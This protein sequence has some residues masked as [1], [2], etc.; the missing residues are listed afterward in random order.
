MLIGS[1][2]AACDH[3]EDS[4]ETAETSP[5]STTAEPVTASTAEAPASTAT[6]SAQPATSQAPVPTEPLA[7]PAVTTTIQSE[8]ALPSTSSTTTDPPPTTTEAPPSTTTSTTTTTSSTTTTTEPPP[9]TSTTTT[10]APPPTTTTTTTI[11]RQP[12]DAIGISAG[13]F[14]TCAILETSEIACWGSCR[15]FILGRNC[16]EDHGYSRPAKI[17][18]LSDVIAVSSSKTNTS[19]NGGSFRGGSGHSCALLE[20]KTLKCWG[21]NDSGQLGAG[22]NKIFS[23]EPV[24]VYGVSNAVD[25][26]S[27]CIVRATGKVACWGEV[28]KEI[29]AT[30]TELPNI[31]NAIAIS[32][33][34]TKLCILFSTEKVACYPNID[35]RRFDI[36]DMYG[37]SRYEIRN[38]DDAIALSG[39]TRTGCALRS[40]G[41]VSCWSEESRGINEGPSAIEI[42]GISEAID[43]AVINANLTQEH[44]A[45]QNNG[46]L[47]CWQNISDQP[48][49]I[50]GIS[51]IIDIAIDKHGLGLIGCALH[52]NGTVT[53]WEGR[54]LETFGEF[55]SIEGVDSAESIIVDHR[56]A[57]AI[58]QSGKAVCWGA[59]S[60]LWS[61]TFEANID[62]PELIFDNFSQIIKIS[63]NSCR[64]ITGLAHCP[65]GFNHMGQTSICALLSNGSVYCMGANF[66]G[67]LGDGSDKSS[68]S[69]PS[70]VQNLQGVIDVS[71]NSSRSSQLEYTCAVKESSKIFCWGTYK[72]SYPFG[73]SKPLEVT[74]FTDIKKIA[75]SAEHICALNNN[76]K[77][78][79]WGYHDSRIG[80]DRSRA[81]LEELRNR[82]FLELNISNAVDISVGSKHSCA[83][84]QGGS[85]ICWGDNS[86]GQ[87][88]NSAYEESSTPVT[89]SGI[90]DA[91]A[92]SSGARH[93]CAIRR[94]NNVVCWGFG[95]FG[96]LGNGKTHS[97][98]EP[99]EVIG[100]SDAIKISSGGSHSCAVRMNKNVVCWGSNVY[101]QLG[102]PF[103]DPRLE[104]VEFIVGYVSYSSIPLEVQGL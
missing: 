2:L 55:K 94:N 77:V 68:V 82:G 67:E 88:G 35:R 40:N 49:E 45:V 76:G 90:S 44:C 52:K 9:P 87:L 81:A 32:S 42:S 103:E 64:D 85:I 43:I 21:R 23:F 3:N 78:F 48:L 69:N 101:G 83:L 4:T 66:N 96:I 62:T 99:V 25:L 51:N 33:T 84:L 63:V 37:N 91:I 5:P 11:P 95:D 75:T 28:H 27:S 17:E 73:N 38:L 100:I 80:Y 72:F 61:S 10:E 24:K 47:Y 54:A 1:L 22:I 7:S 71:V 46:K 59:N 30:P 57:C 6:A 36:N 60:S 86:A 93:N 98:Y 79:C 97:S 74:G 58:L 31:T 26:D 89:V 12:L 8:V 39:G 34:E 13:N 29:S 20:N 19:I 16:L 53:C 65:Y 14:H 18:G 102:V 92:I 15:D 41:K 70:E 50:T 56:T 104:K